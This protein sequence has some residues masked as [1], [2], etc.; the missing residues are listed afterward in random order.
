[1]LLRNVAQVASVYCLSAILPDGKQE[2]MRLMSQNSEPNRPWETNKPDLGLAGRGTK[3]VVIDPL[4]S[5]VA[6]GSGRQR[7]VAS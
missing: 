5:D 3:L 4:E 1:M 6:V 7:C 2:A